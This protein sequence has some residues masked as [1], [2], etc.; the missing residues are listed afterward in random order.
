[1]A[2]DVFRFKDRRGELS[3]ELTVNG[4]EMTGPISSARQLLINL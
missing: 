1:M 4:D 3:G 2:G